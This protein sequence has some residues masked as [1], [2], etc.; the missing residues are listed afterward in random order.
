MRP[1]KV[2]L[3]LPEQDRHENSGSGTPVSET[4]CSSGI[5]Q[6]CTDPTL[7]FIAFPLILGVPE[8]DVI[9]EFLKVPLERAWPVP[10]ER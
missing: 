9:F 7:V 8:Y 3:H 2:P 10:G 1:K 5:F 4:V 6:A